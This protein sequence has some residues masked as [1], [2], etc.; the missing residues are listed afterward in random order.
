MLDLFAHITPTYFIYLLYGASFLFLGISITTKD[1][2]GSDLE[3]ANCLWLL[4]AFGFTHGAHEWI[5]MGSR[6]EGQNLS[7]RQI[8]S[9]QALA[10]GLLILSFICLLQFGLSLLWPRDKIRRYLSQVVPAFFFILWLLYPTKQGWLNEIE[11]LQRTEMGARYTFGVMGSLLSSY[12][13]ITYSQ[14]IRKVSFLVAQRL[15]YAGITFVFYAVFAGLFADDSKIPP[16]SVPIEFFRTVAA[17][18]MTFFMSKALNIFDIE[19]RNRMVQQTH[20]LAQA[21]KLISLGQLA[22]GIAH[23]INNPLTNA[24]L[25]IY[26]LKNKVVEINGVDSV[27]IEKLNTLERNIDRASLIAGELLHFSRK[28]GETYTS[29]NIN[30]IITSSLNL[31]HH[32]RQ[33]IILTCDL[34]PVPDIMGNPVKLEEVFINILSNSIDAMPTG[35]SLSITSMQKDSMIEV[36]ITDTGTG[37]SAE[38]QSRVFEPFFTTKDIGSGTGLGLAVAYSI[39]QQHHGLIKLSSE[40]GKGTAVTVKIPARE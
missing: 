20:L 21:D 25:V 12:A 32:K 4:A 9:V 11:L 17:I 14:K 37:I 36:M 19:M 40:P 26:T 39:I 30:N 29:L 34:K 1:M 15:F 13:L 22:A 5:E 28:D 27:F 35:G 24:S 8:I 7:V 18:F 23:E 33:D 2:Q 38:N 16:F 10:S 3:I 6:I 31:L